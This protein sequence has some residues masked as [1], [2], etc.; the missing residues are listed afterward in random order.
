MA[1]PIRH[2]SNPAGDAL[3]KTGRLSRVIDPRTRL[4]VEAPVV[5]ILRTEITKLQYP[6]A[7]EVL[8]RE[9]ADPPV[10]APVEGRKHDMLFQP[11]QVRV[12]PPVRPPRPG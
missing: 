9:E 5:Q 8:L 2:E 1:V 4:V 7:L 3:Q 12:Y 11:L 10:R 6:F